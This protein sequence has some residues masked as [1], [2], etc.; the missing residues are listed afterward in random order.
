MDVLAF[1]FRLDRTGSVATVEQGTTAE[2]SQLLAVLV[3]TLLGERE[4]TPS[5]GVTDPA[6]DTIDHAEVA[7]GIELF[8]PDVDIQA[9]DVE[10]TDNRTQEV[11]I[12]Y[13]DE[14]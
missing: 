5:F 10:Y 1:P 2:H 6:F 13:A 12:N 4:M 14:S 3:T 11:R 7:A 8:G 9:V